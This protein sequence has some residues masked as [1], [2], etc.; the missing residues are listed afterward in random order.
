MRVMTGALVL[1]FAVVIGAA[2]L[3]GCASDGGRTEG[4]RANPLYLD[5]THPIPTFESL[6]EK[7][8]EPKPQ[9]A[10]WGQQGHTQL[11]QAGGAGH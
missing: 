2:V 3:S 11:F 7:P 1:G 6:A 9:Q 10:A 8:G 4:A 5:L